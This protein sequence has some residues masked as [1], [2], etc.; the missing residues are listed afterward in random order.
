M[1]TVKYL[2]AVFTGLFLFVACEKEFSLESGFAGKV[3]V[4]TLLDTANNC[5]DIIVNGAYFT[6]STVLDSN[7][8]IVQVNID[9]GGSYNIFTDTQNGFSFQDSGIVAAGLHNIK[10]KA[11]GRP[12]A[13]KQ[14]LFQVAFGTSFC[15]FTVTVVNNNPATYTL[16]SGS[17]TCSNATPAGTYTTGT[18]L[19]A[20]NTVSLAVNVTAIGSYSV[21]TG[22]VNGMSFSGTGSFTSVGLQTI[23]LQGSGTPTVA[24]AN[25]F[26]VTAGSSNCTFTIT[27]N[28]GGT[29]VTD[30]N[31]SDTAWSFT[32]GAKSFNGPFLDVFDTTVNNTYGLVFIGYTPTTADSLLYFGTFFTGTTI[33]PGIYSTK[34]TAVFDFTDYRDTANPK[35]IYTADFTTSAADTRLTI[36]SYD[37]TTKIVRGT[38]TGTAMNAA[39]APVPITNGR[40][41]AKVR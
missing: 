38:I 25:A 31:D 40:F 24:G 11:R 35:T 2:L 27:V 26:P 8:V 5:K 39:N 22:A 14:T 34:A 21:K 9:S 32:Q 20:S 3:A 13:A 7:Y 16:V 23:T 12:V 18:A 10:L 6:D 19:N 41:T 1:K 37:A 15:S 29:V 17:G 30:P 4:G 33:Q 36:S 28:P